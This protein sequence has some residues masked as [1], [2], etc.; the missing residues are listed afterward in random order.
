MLLKKVYLTNFN[1][2]A[3]RIN[4]GLVILLRLLTLTINVKITQ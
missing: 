2:Q 3:Q 4:F 1:K